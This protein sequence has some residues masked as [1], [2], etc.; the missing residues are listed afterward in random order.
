MQSS[1]EWGYLRWLSLALGNEPRK[2]M[3]PFRSSIPFQFRPTLRARSEKRIAEDCSA[4]HC[5][6]ALSA[7]PPG[8]RTTQGRTIFFFGGAVWISDV[9][10]SA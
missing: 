7:S 1:V 4:F 3:L 2:A 5:R 9:H 8:K 10:F 6:A